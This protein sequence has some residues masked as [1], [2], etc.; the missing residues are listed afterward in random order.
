MSGGETMGVDETQMLA[1]TF[2]TAIP[3]AMVMAMAMLGHGGS[4]KRIAK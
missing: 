4:V 1:R 3:I 2:S